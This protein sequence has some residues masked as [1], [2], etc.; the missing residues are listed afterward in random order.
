LNGLLVYLSTGADGRL[1]FLQQLSTS[2]TV[3]DFV[4]DR[5][6][7]DLI[8]LLADKGSIL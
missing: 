1:T 5:I 3:W 4:F 2:S 7:G 6:S 8:V